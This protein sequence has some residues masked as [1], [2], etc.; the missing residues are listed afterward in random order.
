MMMRSYTMTIHFI[1]WGPGDQATTTYTLF[2][3][4]LMMS[5]ALLPPRRHTYC[6][7]IY[8]SQTVRVIVNYSQKFDVHAL[9]CR[10]L[11]QLLLFDWLQHRR[12]QQGGLGFV[13]GCSRNIELTEMN[14]SDI[15]L[16][17]HACVLSFMYVVTS[18]S[19]ADRLVDINNWVWLPI[20]LVWP[21]LPE[22]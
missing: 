1:F 14:E 19:S 18:H 5:C 9:F 3:G 7:S 11:E 2:C 17:K 10:E 22:E 21:P 20:L 8:C 16:T 12:G 6:T 4:R 15:I 13:P